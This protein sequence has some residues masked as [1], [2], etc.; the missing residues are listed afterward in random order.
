MT[1]EEKRRE[2]ERLKAQKK[3]KRA[4]EKRIKTKILIILSSIV[5]VLAVLLILV[6]VILLRTR[7]QA[8]NNQ[9]SAEAVASFSMEYAGE[10]TVFEPLPEVTEVVEEEVEEKEIPVIDLSGII[11][12]NAY[13]A[14]LEDGAL[15][16]EKGGSDRIY[17]ASMAKMLTAIV[18][19]ENTDAENDTYTF[20]GSEFD[21]AYLEGA[22]T[23][24]F[25]AGETVVI[26]DILYGA[27]LPS[28]ADACYALANRVAGSESAFVDMMNAKAADIGMENSHFVNCTGLQN[29]EQYSTCED[30]AKLLRYALMNDIF[31]SVYTTHV[32]TTNPTDKHQKGIVLS[33]TTFTYLT[34]STLENDTVIEGGK[35]GFTDEAGRCLASLAITKGQTEYILVTAGAISAE[36]TTPQIA[37]AVAVYSQLP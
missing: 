32:Y 24:G 12:T 37:D 14:R 15:V 20:D 36:S 10:K 7:I 21:M 19:I 2:Q 30:I 6:L 4:K 28:G 31:R 17:P 34:S 3:E 29:E 35:T 13:M 26:K 1:A 16:A 25:S 9:I 27:L 23:A 8:D 33:S 18:A 22:T 11:S 5:A